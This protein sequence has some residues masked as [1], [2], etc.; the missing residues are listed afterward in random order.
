MPARIILIGRNSGE[1]QILSFCLEPATALGSKS[2][3]R[4][5]SLHTEK[6]SRSYTSH[7][8]CYSKCPAEAETKG[9]YP[10]IASTRHAAAVHQTRRQKPVCHC[11]DSTASSALPSLCAEQC[12]GSVQ[13]LLLSAGLEQ[14]LPGLPLYTNSKASASRTAVWFGAPSSCQPLMCVLLCAFLE[15]CRNSCCQQG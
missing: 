10:R 14:L 5:P 4:R 9:R 15:L 7:L 3:W 1:L 2:K 8:I 13:Q 12:P 11:Q 6:K